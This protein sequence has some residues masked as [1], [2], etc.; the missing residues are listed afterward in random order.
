[1]CSRY[2]RAWA[3]FLWVIANPILTFT[4][5]ALIFKNILKIELENYPA[6]LVSGLLPWFFISQSLYVVTN[7]LVTSREVLLGFKI[8]P[9]TIISSQVLDQFVSFSVAFLLIGSFTIKFGVHEPFLLKMI[10]VLMSTITLCLFT[11]F[12]TNL[13]AF[14]HVFYRDIQFIVQFAMN[15]AFYLTPIFYEAKSLG[16]YQWI[17]KFNFFYP[18]IQLY[19]SSLY[20]YNLTQWGHSF[21][22]C[23]MTTSIVALLLH[24]SYRIKMKEF[25]IHV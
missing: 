24:L 23:A 15:L 2:R 21:S 10:L 13:V 19:Q 6:F 5:Q 25:Y 9:F 12:I 16:P 7:A 22:L 3:G 17:L 1:M 11:V 8:H 4:I 20:T 14:W 18:F